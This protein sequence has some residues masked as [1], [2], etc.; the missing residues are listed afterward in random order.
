VH[1]L[2]IIVVT[3]F[4][5]ITGTG[6]PPGVRASGG[7]R[8]T[9][10][11]NPESLPAVPSLKPWCK[12]PAVTSPDTVERDGSTV[13]RGGS[14]VERDGSTESRAS[15]GQAPL[16]R[17]GW[18][19]HMRASITISAKFHRIFF[20]LSHPTQRRVPL[21]C[22]N[23][24]HFKC[25]EC[26]TTRWS[27]GIR[28]EAKYHYAAKSSSRATGDSQSHFCTGVDM[29]NTVSHFWKSRYRGLVPLGV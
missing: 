8:V 15:S 25:G 28:I 14:T 23:I 12:S 27:R 1:R 9:G 5:A 10:R 4:V 6:E 17:R 16:A 11:P 24:G 7:A 22:C 18:D 2:H 29:S 3:R 26:S 19:D 13:E 21:L 20:S